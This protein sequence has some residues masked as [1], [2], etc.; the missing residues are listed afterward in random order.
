MSHVFAPT[1]S[2][3]HTHCLAFFFQARSELSP[4]HIKEFTLRIL[5]LLRSQDILSYTRCIL[6]YSIENRTGLPT[7]N[8]CCWFKCIFPCLGSC[9]R[10]KAMSTGNEILINMKV[11]GCHLRFL[12]KA[13][14]TELT[15]VWADR[16]GHS[17]P[18]NYIQHSSIS[19]RRRFRKYKRL[20][21]YTTP[22]WCIEGWLRGGKCQF[23]VGLITCTHVPL[24]KFYI[25]IR[26]ILSVNLFT[27]EQ[28]QLFLWDSSKIP[29]LWIKQ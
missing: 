9:C 1:L 19:M 18:P 3:R 27:V 4:K 29:L 13:H 2:C 10:T 15:G 25:H 5:K 28:A 17:R 26:Y 12:A 6:S 21:L 11:L 16:F 24:N 14:L 20:L 22:W 8:C 7:E 23:I